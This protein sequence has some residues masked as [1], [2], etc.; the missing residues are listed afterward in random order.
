[1]GLFE[2]WLSASDKV[3]VDPLTEAR[4]YFWWG[5]ANTAMTVFMMVLFM[6]AVLATELSGDRHETAFTSGLILWIF[7][8]GLAAEFSFYRAR[9]AKAKWRSTQPI[10]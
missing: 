4:R 3:A 9:Q 6:W 8:W 7:V 10:G 2:W 1:M 5:V